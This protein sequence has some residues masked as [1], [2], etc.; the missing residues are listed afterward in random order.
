MRKLGRVQQFVQDGP[1]TMDASY[2]M[3]ADAIE[4]FGQQKNPE[5]VEDGSESG[6]NWFMQMG[7][8]QR[9]TGN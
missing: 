2:S 3:T 4:F 5:T 8:K 9:A 7:D 6:N 1:V